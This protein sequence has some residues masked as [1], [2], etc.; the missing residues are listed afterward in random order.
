MSFTLFDEDGFMATD[1]EGI[2]WCDAEVHYQV[3][4][5]GKMVFCRSY[6]ECG[7]LISLEPMPPAP[8]EN[9][10]KQLEREKADIK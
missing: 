9:A 7:R 6:D 4:L 5:E 3:N 2:E 10:I 1:C 8:A